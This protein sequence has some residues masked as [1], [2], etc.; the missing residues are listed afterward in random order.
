MLPKT[1]DEPRPR[2]PYQAPKVLSVESIEVVAAV[3]DPPVGGFGKIGP[4]IC[5]A[6]GS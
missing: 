2:R 1:E 4:P 3:C 6:L 5:G